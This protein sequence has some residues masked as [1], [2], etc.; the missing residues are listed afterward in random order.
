M[1]ELIHKIRPERA[2]DARAKC[3]GDTGRNIGSTGS[4]VHFIHTHTHTLIGFPDGSNGKE[5]V[6]NVRNPSSSPGLGISPGE[7]N[8][9]SLQ[10]SRLENSMDRGT[11]WMQSLGPLKVRHHWVTNTH[12]HIYIFVLFQIIFHHV[13]SRWS[14]ARLFAT[15]WTI[16]HFCGL[17]CL[18]GFPGKNTGVGCHLLLQFSNRLLQDIEYSSLCYT[19]GPCYLS[20]LYIVV[21]MSVHLNLVIYPPPTPF[22]L[23]QP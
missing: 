17:L 13:F 10:C 15:P 14:R 22:P 6:C 11:W 8:G 20:I 7:G 2:L 3:L 4:Y 12:T 18:W 5:S 21:C 19:V 1:G 23:R 9:N 16:A